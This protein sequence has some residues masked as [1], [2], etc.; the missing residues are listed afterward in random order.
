MPSG[1]SWLVVVMHMPMR[2]PSSGTRYVRRHERSSS[3][4]VADMKARKKSGI[5]RLVTPP[6]RLPQPAAVAL[7]TPM[8]LLLNICAHQ[9][10]A[11][12]KV[13]SEKPIRKRHLGP[14]WKAQNR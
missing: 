10:C 3:C 14:C 4:P 7:A 6:P 12:T 9:V 2:C 8:I 5:V 1:R 13:A 11:H